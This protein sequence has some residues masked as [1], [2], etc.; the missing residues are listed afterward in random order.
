VF[1]QALESIKANEIQRLRQLSARLHIAK[2]KSPT[3]RESCHIGVLSQLPPDLAYLRRPAL[4]YNGMVEQ[5]ES[6]EELEHN[7]EFI[8]PVI[9]AID[10]AL[11]Q[12]MAGLSEPAS[13][14]RIV[15]DAERLGTWMEQW[16]EQ[17]V[18]ELMGL[19]VVSQFLLADLADLDPD[20]E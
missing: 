6:P 16:A 15:A 8:D 13:H 11:Q 14:E 4:I 2:M 7:P 9:E 17:D 1:F 12:E 20:E 18:P 5:A 10:A 3:V 19:Y